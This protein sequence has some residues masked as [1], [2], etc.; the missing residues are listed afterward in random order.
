MP[1]IS[2]VVKHSGISKSTVSRVIN[3]HPNVS[4]AK[5][6]KVLKA[7]EELSYTPNPTARKMRGKVKSTIGLVIPNVTN[8]FFSYLVE[9]AERTASEN[10]Y[11]LIILQSKEDKQK[12]LDF[13]NLLKLKQ[14]D[15]IILAS[16]ENDLATIQSYQEYGAIVFCNE[17]LNQNDI[18]TVKV[19]Q[20]VAAYNGIH[21]LL[22]KGYK[23]IAYCTGGLFIEEGKDKDRNSG[24]RKAMEESGL[25]INPE[26]I[27][28]EQHNIEDGKNV[29]KKILK[30]KE[31]PD[32]IFTGSDEVASGIT[33]GA[34]ES[35][36]KIPD[37]IAVLGFDDQPISEITYP[38]LSTIHQPIEEMGKLATELMIRLFLEEPMPEKT[39]E[40][41]SNVVE[42][43][44]T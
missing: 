8:P 42:R 44:S 21:H 27:F 36:I 37:D 24:F 7:M 22:K 29:L 18:P 40:L 11:R 14:I 19:D 26:W 32:A 35:G 10:N 20:A 17:Y 33:L 9:S 41:V 4:K 3:N 43:E 31:K 38:R 23:K 28:I 12:E 1:T 5:R 25:G 30:M 34:R 6:E 39:Y 2:D 15:G 16:I 13:L